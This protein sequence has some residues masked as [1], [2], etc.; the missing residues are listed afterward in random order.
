MWSSGAP[1]STSGIATT[2]EVVSMAKRISRGFGK[3]GAT[4]PQAAVK[5][6]RSKRME[7]AAEIMRGA[8]FA[9]GRLA[10]TLFVALWIAAVLASVFV[11]RA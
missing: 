11:L 7:N 9:H 8:L 2:F 3:F 4:E 5:P 6:A 10:L 1:L